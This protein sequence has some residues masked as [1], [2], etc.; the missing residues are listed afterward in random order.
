[1][2]ILVP[3]QAVGGVISMTSTD[4]AGNTSEIGNGLAIDTVFADGVD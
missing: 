2:P 1:M 3:S 4:A